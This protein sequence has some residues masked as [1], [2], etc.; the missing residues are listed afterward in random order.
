MC[1]L[2]NHVGLCDKGFQWSLCLNCLC[3][4]HTATMGSFSVGR[5]YISTFNWLFNIISSFCI[6]LNSEAS[7]MF[8]SQLMLYVE[9]VVVPTQSK[10]QCQETL[11]HPDSVSQC[12]AF[13]NPD[14]TNVFFTLH[15]CDLHCWMLPYSIRM[16]GWILTQWAGHQELSAE[17]ERGGRGSLNFFHF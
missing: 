4:T 8:I 9:Y 13:S 10:T 14:S 1:L 16:C 5:T 11:Q 17:R 15:R 3:S 12:F 7:V 2:S 6:A